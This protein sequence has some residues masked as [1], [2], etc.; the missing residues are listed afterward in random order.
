MLGKKVRSKGKESTGVEKDKESP[1]TDTNGVKKGR[2][3]CRRKGQRT[4]SKSKDRNTT[5]RS[6]IKNRGGG[7]KWMPKNMLLK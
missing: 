2:R 1:F 4:R 7:E 6:R 3:V 5:Y